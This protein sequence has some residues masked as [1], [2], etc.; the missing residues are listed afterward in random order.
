MAPMTAS[1]KEQGGRE[2]REEGEETAL[3][4][5]RNDDGVWI[6][7][8]NRPHRGNAI[9]DGLRLAMLEA[10]GEAAKDGECRVMVITGKGKYFC[11]GMDLA[12][13]EASEKDD[14]GKEDDMLS[15]SEELF[16]AVDKFPKPGGWT[17]TLLLLLKPCFLFIPSFLPPF[18]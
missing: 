1:K 15:Q 13:R 5:E 18:Q 8:L 17:E 16:E 3:L 2:G 9:N 6:L 14:G 10:L 11:T 7:T 12:R 4:V